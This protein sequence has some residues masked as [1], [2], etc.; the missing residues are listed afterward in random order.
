MVVGHPWAVHENP[1][2]DE[3]GEL[4]MMRQS[5]EVVF[6]PS[7]VLIN[8]GMYRDHKEGLILWVPCFA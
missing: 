3:G 6:C 1:R 2:T 7:S 8:A 4:K 5:N